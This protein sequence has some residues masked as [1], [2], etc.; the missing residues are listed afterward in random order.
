MF[1]VSGDCYN[2]AP[3]YLKQKT[4]LVIIVRKN[5]RSEYEQIW[6][7]FHFIT[8][9]YHEVQYCPDMSELAVFSIE[10]ST[11]HT[12]IKKKSY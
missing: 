11:R 3:E 4:L 1:F 2:Y 6:F 10:T 8:Y 5:R 9:F 7:V 12:T